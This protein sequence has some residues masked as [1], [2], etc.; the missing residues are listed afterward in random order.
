MSTPRK[1][2]EHLRNPTTVTFL[3]KKRGFSREL[4]IQVQ[5][6]LSQSQSS[7]DQQVACAAPA[8]RMLNSKL[9]APC[10]SSVRHQQHSLYFHEA[11][12][13]APRL[14]TSAAA[15]AQQ[16]EAT[17]A[18]AAAAAENLKAWFLQHAEQPTQ[19]EPVVV[20]SRG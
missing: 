4:D 7:T 12:I 20:D 17:G 11:S 15:A 19:L 2:L 6:Q 16:A 1:L 14:R 9:Q 5:G 13:H 8:S 10:N 18:A 3:D